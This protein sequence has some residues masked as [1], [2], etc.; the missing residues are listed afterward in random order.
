[1][2]VHTENVHRSKA[3]QGEKLED[4]DLF[5]LYKRKQASGLGS[6]FSRLFTVFD[7]SEANG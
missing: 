5:A 3:Q 7:T 2:W 4:L 1:M 6:L